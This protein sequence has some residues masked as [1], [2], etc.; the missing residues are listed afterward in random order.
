MGALPRNPEHAPKLKAVFTTLRQ[1]HPEVSLICAGPSTPEFRDA[2]GALGIPSFEDPSRAVR[3]A[4]ALRFFA[5]DPRQAKLVDRRCH[6]PLLSGPMDELEALRALR[7][8]GIPTVDAHLATDAKSAAAAARKV[9]FPVVMKVASPDILHKSDFGG[10]MLGLTSGDEVERGFDGLIRRARRAHPDASVHGCLIAPMIEGGVE[11]VLGTICDP[12]FGPVVMVG[13]GGIFVEVLRDVVLRVAPVDI[14]QAHEMLGELQGFA[15][16]EGAR[17][18][19]RMDVE[20][21]AQAVVDLSSF[22]VAHRH[23]IV[24][25]DVNPFLVLTNGAVALDAAIVR[26]TPS[27]KESA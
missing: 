3:A 14:A 1:R 19:P 24:S 15:M 12:I 16:L 25:C 22:A 5:V 21:L 13:L 9:G 4:A 23:D 20:A 10:V 17:G 11:I 27:G 8:A 18:R 26:N 6:A 7:A 2:L